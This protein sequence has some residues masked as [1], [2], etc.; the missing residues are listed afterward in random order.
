[1]STATAQELVWAPQ[2]GPQ[3]ALLECPVEDV[4]FG[5]A[6]GGGKSDGILGDW[7]A[8]QHRYGAAARGLLVRR[9][10]PEFEELLDRAS[11]LFGRAGASFNGTER[12]WTFPNGA[13]IRARYLAKDKDADGMQGWSNTWIGVDEVGN[14]PSP[15]PIDK[16]RATLRSTVPGVAKVMRSSANPGGPGHSWVKARYIDPA[17]P[18]TP[19][20]AEEKLPD[21][22][23][24]TVRR[25]F[26][27]STIEDNTLLLTA[28]P[29]YWERVALAAAG[30]E[31]LLKAWRF[32]L[33]DIVAGGY[34]DAVWWP[35]A[36]VLEPFPIPPGWRLDRSFDWGSSKPFAVCWW[37]ESN[38]EPVE[39]RGRTYG[40]VRGDLFL[41]AEWYGWNGSPNEGCHML[42]REIARGIKK[43]EAKWGLQVEP[44][45]A[46]TSIYTRENGP[47]IAD[48]MEKEGV[49][50]TKADKAPGSRKAG[51]HTMLRMLTD[52]RATAPREEPGLFVFNH[53]RHF[54]RTV[55]VLQRDD[56][57]NDDVDTKGEDHIADA[58]RYR[59]NHRPKL[60]KQR[61]FRV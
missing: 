46:D 32:G 3:R 53:C 16:L 9:S 57:D 44:G 30:Q 1:M 36:H 20:T 8:H 43:L 42:A 10:Y 61:A 17:A 18:F 56:R 60:F 37:A 15:K 28:D 45:P 12:R 59:A 33:W 2:E 50:W 23:T 38:G 48:D 34:F 25:V 13:K 19:F 6:R 49:Y 54:I 11:Y 55:P 29:D 35:E 26:I 7:L 52:A 22:T 27:P 4:L 31:W 47:S 24:A 5:G 51:W 41:V 21:G 39:H 14:F 40:S 58:V